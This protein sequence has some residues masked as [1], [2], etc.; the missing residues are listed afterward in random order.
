MDCWTRWSLRKP[1]RSTVSVNMTAGIGNIE[2][3][4]IV[5]MREKQ[6]GS[7]INGLDIETKEQ[8]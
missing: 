2:L 7:I 5:I 4:L 8:R 1:E 6:Q 3:V